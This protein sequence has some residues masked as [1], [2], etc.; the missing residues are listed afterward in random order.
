MTRGAH[1]GLGAAPDTDPYGEGA[2]LGVRHDVLVAERRP[3]PSLPGDRPAL[4]QLGE[5]L[6][7]LLE[8]LLVVGEVITEERERV[9]AGASSEDDLRPAAG[10]RVERGVA[11]KHPDGVV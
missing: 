6:G 11:L 2:V 10:D 9:D 8:E 7:L 1:D 3:G 5:Q 4:D